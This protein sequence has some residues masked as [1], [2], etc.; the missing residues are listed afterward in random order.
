MNK[1]YCI[2][3]SNP[4]TYENNPPTFCSFCGNQFSTLNIPNISSTIV[5][6]KLRRVV[7]QEIDD[8]GDDYV[9]DIPQIKTLEIEDLG[10]LRTTE[11]IAVL[12]LDKSKPEVF[13]RP[14]EKKMTKKEFQEKWM[15]DMQKRGSQNIGGET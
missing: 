7:E 14:K 2:K 10:N 3:C 9:V 6:P 4:T 11:K 12:A 15:T 5:K 13:N 1:K 8:D